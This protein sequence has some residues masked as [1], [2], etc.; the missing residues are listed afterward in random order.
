MVGSP[1]TLTQGSYSPAPLSRTYQWRLCDSAGNNCSDISGANSNTYTPVAGQQG[2]TLRVVETVSQNGYNNASSTSA[3]KTVV[4][5]PIT[6]NSAVSINGMPTVGTATT[7]T[8]GSYSP[9]PTSF[10]YQWQL[11]NPGCSDISGA[12]SSTYTPVAGDVG[13]TLKV[14]ETAKKFGYS[15]GTSTS[16]AS[17]PV[18]NGSFSTNT[19]PLVN[20]TPKVGTPTTLTAGSYSPTPASRSYQWQLCSPSCSNIYGA[21]SSTYTPVA[22]DVGWTLKVIETV[23][24]AGY[25]NGSSTSAASAAV[26]KASFSTT[27]AVA[28]NGT[29][30]VG[31]ATTITAGVYSPTPT[32]SPAYQWRLCDSNGSFCSDISG[33]NGNTYTPISSQ[34]GSTLRV[35]ETVSKPGYN[36]ASSTSSA[37]VVNGVFATTTPVAIDETPKVGVQGTTTGGTYSPTPT[38]RSYQWKRCDTSGNN[39]VLIADAIYNTYTPVAADVGKTLRVVETVKKANYVTG[40][41]TSAASPLVVKGTFDMA[42]R[43]AVFGYPKHGVSS[44]V[45]QGSYT[46]NPTSRAY[47]WMRCTDTTLAS[48]VDISGATAKTY[49]PVSADIGKRLRVEE[50]VMAPGYNNLSVTSLASTAVT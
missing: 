37:V 2:S 7:L 28:I 3:R 29:P 33:A 45:T 25:N 10:T 9:T 32:L 17:Q 15:N 24:Q 46:P 20:G 4:V 16:A 18:A 19:A 40:S 26:I 14:V 31:I 48:C 39:C 41:S 27:T 50:T 12:T 11:C 23:T 38:G 13:G 44:G 47:Q 34:I 22:G 21:T 49:T 35:V 43:V 6:T 8:A 1:S 42:E 30:T 5:G 36:N